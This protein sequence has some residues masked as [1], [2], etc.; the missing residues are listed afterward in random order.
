MSD[1]SFSIVA[2]RIRVFS[3]MTVSLFHHFLSYVLFEFVFQ[4]LWAP[5]FSGGESRNK[6]NRITFSV[7][8]SLHNKFHSA[9]ERRVSRLESQEVDWISKNKTH[10]DLF[11]LQTYRISFDI[12]MFCQH[13]NIFATTTGNM[14]HFVILNGRNRADQS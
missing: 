7:S 4:I 12:L 10:P 11:F 5:N 3:T 13:A 2:I 1:T 14:N 6:L 8:S 9:A